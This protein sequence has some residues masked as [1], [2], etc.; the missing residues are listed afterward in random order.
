MKARIRSQPIVRT[1]G[2]VR[3]ALWNPFGMKGSVAASRLLAQRNS[4]G[5]IR[6]GVKWWDTQRGRW[7]ADWP[8]YLWGE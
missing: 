2:V 4:A 6:L 7:R 5:L 8:P 3:V 1:D